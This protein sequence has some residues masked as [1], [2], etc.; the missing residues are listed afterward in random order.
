MKSWLK[1]A[2]SIELV[3]CMTAIQAT[4]LVGS[5]VKNWERTRVSPKRRDLYSLVGDDVGCR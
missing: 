2:K 5:M 3:R 4:E 1:L